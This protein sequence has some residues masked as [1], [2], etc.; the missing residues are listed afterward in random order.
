MGRL[1]AFGTSTSAAE[2]RPWTV[3]EEDTSSSTVVV[4]HQMSR[5][6]SEGERRLGLIEVN[7]EGLA[8]D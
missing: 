8:T 3:E 5:A 1:W 2:L 7:I 6:K 4:L